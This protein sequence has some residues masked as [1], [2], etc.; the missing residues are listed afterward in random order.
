VDVRTTWLGR[1]VAVFLFA[2]LCGVGVHSMHAVRAQAS[3]SYP[4]L[5]P[6]ASTSRLLPA[7]APGAGTA[8]VFN[9]T[10]PG[11]RP[12]TYDPCRP[13]H[14]VIE[15][16]HLPTY[17][18][19]MVREAVAKVSAATGLNFVEDGMTT[20]PLSFKRAKVQSRYGD[21]WAPV[22][23][24]FSDGKQMPELGTGVMGLGGSVSVAPDGPA[25]A[26]YVTGTV[27]VDQQDFDRTM[28]YANGWDK[29]RA[30]IMH[31]LGHVVGLA[32]AKDPFQL[33]YSQNN[34]LIAFGS[35]DDAGLA[36]EGSGTCHTDT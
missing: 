13:V 19:Q 24:G 17:G 3:E 23:I 7:P 29:D 1:V 34:G 5:P 4:P 28:G 10:L 32:H 36:L 12:V 16:G 26:R 27:A 20:E 8:Y 35:G 22:L 9:L 6:D 33:M 11:G 21:R 15:S 31:E 18:G 14:Y 30:V 2:V 25:S